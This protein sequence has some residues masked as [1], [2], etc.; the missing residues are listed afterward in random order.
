M[1]QPRDFGFGSHEALVRDQ[2]GVRFED[3]R[4]E[5][6]AADGVA[7]LEAGRRAILI[8]LAQVT[9]VRGSPRA[10]HRDRAPPGPAP[11]PDGEG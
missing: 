10:R 4:T 2:A 7:A 1:T 8:V 6:L 5:P 11:S 9:A 3:V